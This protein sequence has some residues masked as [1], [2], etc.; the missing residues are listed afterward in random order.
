MNEVYRYLT[1]L[2]I[3]AMVGLFVFA[4]LVALI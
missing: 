1:K 4:T 2:T 3:Y